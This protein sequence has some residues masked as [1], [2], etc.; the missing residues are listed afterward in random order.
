MA[1]TINGTA[2]KALGCDN[3]LIVLRNQ[4]EDVATLT[5]PGDFD[6]PASG[7]A[8]NAAVVIARDGTTVFRGT[9]GDYKITQSGRDET[10][11][12]PVNGAWYHATRTVFGQ[13]NAY[14]N[15]TQYSGRFSLG[16]NL[17]TM[18]TSLVDFMV[19]Q[20]KWTKGTI[21]L[22]ALTVPVSEVRDMMVSQAIQAMLRWVPGATVS[23]DYTT[24]SPTVH[25]LHPAS[26]TLQT[27]S[28]ES[29]A[30]DADRVD[31][32]Q[33]NDLAPV[34]VVLQYERSATKRT[35]SWTVANN[36][37]SST[38]SET[39]G[40]N[41]VGIDQHPVGGIVPG[42]LHKTILL[43]GAKRR[44]VVQYLQPAWTTTKRNLTA[45]QSQNNIK[46]LLPAYPSWVV[47]GSYSA[48]WTGSASNMSK[49]SGSGPDYNKVYDVPEAELPPVE[50]WRSDAFPEG[51]EVWRQTFDITITQTVGGSNSLRAQ[52]ERRM[53]LAY[54]PVSG[55]LRNGTVISREFNEDDAD[56]ETMPAGRAAQIYNQLRLSTTVDGTARLLRQSVQIPGPLQQRV[57]VDATR[58]GMLQSASIDAASGLLTLEFGTPRNLAPSDLITLLQT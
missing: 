28:V 12:L 15:V 55:A 58:G 8:Y 10:V 39:T 23:F 44:R 2:A 51:F 14:D 34:N 33:R 38:S 18:V 21:S 49:V 13:T 57:V 24:A 22:P 11:Q 41:Y 4:M 42:T 30:S 19:A 46:F 43:S 48:T 1:W 47:D 50:L 53:V 7:L 27:V 40:Y 9:V 56:L 17:T 37:A 31:T 52:V 54:H 20:G 36:A 29:G 35:E 45:Y 6:A 16:G 32:Q 3:V 25:V 26:P 5:F